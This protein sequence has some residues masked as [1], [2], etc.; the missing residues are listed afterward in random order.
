MK[1]LTVFIW[2]WVALVMLGNLV[3][4][5]GIS[6]TNAV[7]AGEVFD[8]ELKFSLGDIDFELYHAG[9]AHTPGDSF[10]WLP[11]QKVMFSGDI[12]YTERMLGIGEQSNSKSWIS[13]FDAMAAFQPKHVI[14]GH[15]GSTTLKKARTDTYDYLVFIRQ[16]VSDFMEQGGDVSEIRKIDQTDFRY[17]QNY[18]TL[19][20]RN[21]QKVYTELE[22]E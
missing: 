20:G 5:E 22:W 16:A 6:G 21:A 18:D 10:V 4:D 9:Q 2:F 19:A 3:G 8:K 12:V 13:V 11:Q 17:L 7:Y 14:P 15:G 1:A